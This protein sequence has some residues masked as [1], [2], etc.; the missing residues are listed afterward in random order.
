[1]NTEFAAGFVSGLAVVALLDRWI[2]R[3]KVEA[4]VKALLVK[5]EEKTEAR[6]AE[7]VPRLPGLD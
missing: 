2:F 5:L 1:M 6:T 7:R 3:S 4:E